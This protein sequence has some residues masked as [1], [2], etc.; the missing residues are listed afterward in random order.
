MT[1]NSKKAEERITKIITEARAKGWMESA[2]PTEKKHNDKIK[3][4]RERLDEIK[5]NVDQLDKDIARFAV[6]NG[7]DKIFTE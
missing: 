4:N 3:R 7:Y 5:K 6:R 1:T 2:I